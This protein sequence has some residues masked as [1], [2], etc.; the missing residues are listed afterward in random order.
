MQLWGLEGAGE[1]GAV[2]LEAA[3]RKL[4]RIGRHE[5]RQVGE[6]L[7]DG[8]EQVGLTGERA[9]RVRDGGHLAVSADDDGSLPY[10]RDSELGCVQDVRLQ[11]VVGEG[12][13]LD[14]GL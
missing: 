5:R 12:A 6:C 10:L 4:D 14:L 8:L 9:R 11:S 13:V 2:E 3:V 7:A 1:L